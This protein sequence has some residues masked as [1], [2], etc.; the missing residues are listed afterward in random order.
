MVKTPGAQSKPIEILVVKDE[1]TPS[2]AVMD[3]AVTA[4]LSIR[5]LDL[6]DHHRRRVAKQVATDFPGGRAAQ[7]FWFAR[8]FRYTNN[9]AKTVSEVQAEGF[10]VGIEGAR[11]RFWQ[12]L[13]QGGTLTSSGKPFAIPFSRGQV[14]GKRSFAGRFG[15]GSAENFRVI[16][17]GL[18][19]RLAGNE[20]SRSIAGV[21]G[22][23][24]RRGYRTEIVGLLR[25]T[26]E[27][28]RL[29][30]FRREFDKLLPQHL[31]E[32]DRIFDMAESATGRARLEAATN[33]KADEF[34][35]RLAKIRRGTPKEWIPI[36]RAA[37][38]IESRRKR[39][40]QQERSGGG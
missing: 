2:L 22:D 6:V 12:N 1:V 29:L 32:V 8:S 13:E 24:K 26:R 18:I 27:Q 38:V 20:K 15:S 21:G 14:A 9:Y 17:G 3:T 34:A 7:K 37:A 36:T 28:P 11:E 19:V 33:Q 25:R 5:A 39:L 23:V 16:R 4:A 10:A 30:E 31:R 35:A 40:A